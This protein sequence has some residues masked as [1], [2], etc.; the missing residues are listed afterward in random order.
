MLAGVEVERKSEPIGPYGAVP[1]TVPVAITFILA[2][3]VR[4]A[5]G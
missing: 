2:V 1:V 4:E 3:K 5:D